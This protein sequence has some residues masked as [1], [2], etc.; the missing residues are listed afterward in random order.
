MQRLAFSTLG[1]P[2][3]SFEEI[4][5]NAAAYGFSAI[6]IRGIKDELRTEKISAFLPENMDA[7]NKLLKDNNLFISNVGTSVNFHDPS[8]YSAAIDEGK[9][10]IDTCKRAGIPAIRV[11]GDAIPPGEDAA[12]I[13][14]RVADGIRDLCNYSADHTG[15]AVSIW[16][17]IHGDF[18]TPDV[19]LPLVGYLSDVPLYGILW[20]IEHTFRVGTDPVAFYN[21]FKHLIRHTHIKDCIVE[22]GKLIVKLP[23]E[24]ALPIKKHYNLLENGGY[25]GLYSFEWEKRWKP[26]IPEPEIAFKQ[27]IREMEK[28]INK[29]R[30]IIIH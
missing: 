15:G 1:C 23:G 9:N 4:I 20:D 3:W 29:S 26:D 2:D 16:Q 8:N 28:C 27:Y 7:T 12:V 30:K 11:F 19:L 17:E 25:E 10:A 13:I 14:R 21:E 22:D 24:G 18:N 6:E 5:E